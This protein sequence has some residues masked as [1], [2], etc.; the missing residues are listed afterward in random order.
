MAAPSRVVRDEFPSS[1]LAAPVLN[2]DASYFVNGTPEQLA[3]DLARSGYT[4][5]LVTLN[6]SVDA[7]DVPDSA[8]VKLDRM[9]DLLREQ[10]SK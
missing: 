3:A 10:E 5:G 7:T 4:F 8:R 1:R 2:I 6:R 9:A